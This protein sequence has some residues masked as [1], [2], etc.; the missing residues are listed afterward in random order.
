MPLDQNTLVKDWIEH[1]KFSGIAARQ[2]DPKTGKLNYYRQ[3]SYDDLSKFLQRKFRDTGITDQDIDNAIKTSLTKNRSR[4]SA[5][6]APGPGTNVANAPGQPPAAGQQTQIPGPAGQAPQGGPQGTPQGGQP[7][8]PKPLSPEYQKG[9][10]GAEDVEAREPGQ[11][12]AKKSRWKF[13]E[14][15]RD[16]PGPEISEQVVE[17]VFNLLIARIQQIQKE[18]QAKDEANKQQQLQ[19]GLNKILQ[20]VSTLS[21]GERRELYRLLK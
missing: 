4:P 19:Q 2:S 18:K 11:A 15:I 6:P 16:V 9:K 7:T 21:S 3:V 17:E 1:L 20:Y 8:G 14:A 10:E 5:L 13:S 12:P